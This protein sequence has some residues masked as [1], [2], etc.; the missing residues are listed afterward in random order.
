MG[1]NAAAVVS[2]ST[3][4]L[5]HVRTRRGCADESAARVSREE[6]QCLSPVAVGVD[7]SGEL[8]PVGVPAWVRGGIIAT[9]LPASMLGCAYHGD[10][11][12]DAHYQ[13]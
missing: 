3:A 9:L 13:R 8:K 11:V 7:L 6:I 5:R 4:T 12:I 10:D 2:V 1:L